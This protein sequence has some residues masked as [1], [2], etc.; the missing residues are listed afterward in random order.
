VNEARAGYSANRADSRSPAD[1]P[2]MEELGLKGIPL[3]PELTGL[4]AFTIT[5]FGALGDRT[6][7]PY[8]PMARIVQIADNLS[9]AHGAHLFKAGGEVRFKRNM[10]ENLQQGRGDFTFT[11]QFTSQVPGQATGSG[12]ADLL[13]GQ[14]SVARL[15][16]PLS[17]DFQD[18]YYA[19][20]GSDAWKI[21]SDVTLNLGVRYEVQTPMWERRDRMASFDHDPQNPTFGALVSARDGDLRAR[22][23]SRVDLDNVAP[24]VGLTWQLTPQTAVRGA[25]GLFYGGLGFQ[26]ALQ[27]GL[28]NVP[29]F[30]RVTL[31]SAATAR[32]SMLTLGGGFKA[33]ALDPVKVSNPDA[34][35]VAPD[36]PLG[37]VHQWHLSIERQLASS[38]LL[39]VA[40]VGS[41][42]SQLR[43]INNVNAPVPGPGAVQARR[44]FPAFGDVLE[45]SD[46]VEAAYHALQVSVERRLTHGLALIS[47]YT[48]SHALDNATDPGDTPSPV[49][50]QNP[51]DIRAEKAS[52]FFDVRHRFVASVIY[53]SPVGRDGGEAGRSRLVGRLL[54]GWRLAGI[55][56]A[57]T[58]YP[59]TPT[60]RPNSAIS[61]TPLRPDCV[62]DG[63][64]PR[65]ERTIDRWFDVSAFAT[66]APYTFGNCG[67][68][69][70][71]GPGF[72]NLDGAVSREFRVASDKRL[73]L[74][75]EVFNVANAVHFGPPNVV[76]DEPG[77]AGRITSTQAPPRQAQLGLRFV[78]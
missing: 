9:W 70:L 19:A 47:N 42:S 4:P 25:Y 74:R 13:L 34:F 52:A 59:L 66:P 75:V 60:L 54:G 51:S 20:Y 10:I 41:D 29:Y 44:R 31:R 36:L 24:R 67:R 17:G 45:A 71:R 56:V 32:T 18:R 3:V 15:S 22:T 28:A 8:R 58:G 40:Y 62:A 35:S 73:E 50:P 37:Q 27:S 77:Q 49:T 46:F 39:T 63:N 61:T 2:L 14:T 72:V 11:G 30:V 7:L 78:F 12:L 76:I 43:G 64:L 38:T 23:F 55:F 1:R 68:N 26:A 69:V 33:D 16:T 5:G 53:E 48:W 65:G 57:Q 6:Q 21:T